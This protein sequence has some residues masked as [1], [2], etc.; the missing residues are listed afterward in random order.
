[1]NK[2][3][4]I[5]NLKEFRDYLIEIL[6]NGLDG[7]QLGAVDKELYKMC[8]SSINFLIDFLKR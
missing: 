6:L 5:E 7:E 2:E 3:F 1:M 8:I 4:L